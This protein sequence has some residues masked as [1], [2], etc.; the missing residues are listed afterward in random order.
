MGNHLI[1]SISLTQVPNVGSVTAKQLISYCGSPEAVFQTPKRQLLKIPGVGEQTAQAILQF[2]DFGR[3]EKEI[4]FLKRHGLRAL[5]YTETDYPDRLKHYPDAPVLLYAR[6][7]AN[8]NPERTLAVVGTRQPSPQGAS[9]CEEIVLGLAPF[10]PQIISGLAYGIDAAAH[11]AALDASLSTVA[12]LGHGLDRVYPQQNQKLALDMTE[13]N[14]ALLT[15]FLSETE[16]DRENFPMRNRIVAAMCDALL[17][18]ETGA[19]GGSM[20]TANLAND[21]HKDVFAVP[22]RVRDPKSE[23][24][25]ALIKNHKANLVESAEDIAYLMQW[26]PPKEGKKERQ[27]TLFA[28]LSSNEQKVLNLMR[29]LDAPL[30]IDHISYQ[31]QL[32]G[33]EIAAALLNLE[34]VGLVKSLPGKRFTP[35]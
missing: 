15:E 3:A 31:T 10:A 6:G 14:G 35:V 20:I 28:N 1:F 13:K 4:Q 29:Q 26:D 25:N 5:L 32:Q 30:S 33:S 27:M 24:C 11:K 34:F 9:L 22:G 8:L 16:P 19:K 23:G 12:V 17:V 2:R 7:D 21:Y 18:V